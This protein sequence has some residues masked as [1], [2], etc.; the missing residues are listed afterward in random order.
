MNITFKNIASMN[1][2]KK[3][4]VKQILRISHMSVYL[5]N[6]FMHSGSTVVSASKAKVYVYPA[7]RGNMVN[8]LL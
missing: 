8:S 2:D 5:S 4:Q 3:N 1:T 7:S 6:L